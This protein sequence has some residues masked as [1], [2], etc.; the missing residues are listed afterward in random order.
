MS[1][2]FSFAFMAVFRQQ[3]PSLP[4]LQGSLTVQRCQH[5][6]DRSQER[7]ACERIW[8]FCILAEQILLVV[9]CCRRYRCLDYHIA[10]LGVDRLW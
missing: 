4:L 2:F 8:S 1:L 6:G 9:G 10:F 3:V 5:L 7:F